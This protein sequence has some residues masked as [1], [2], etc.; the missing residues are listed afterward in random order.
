ME[1]VTTTDETCTFSSGNSVPVQSHI[2]LPDLQLL[3]LWSPGV[4]QD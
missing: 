3:R 2:S 4:S 1:K